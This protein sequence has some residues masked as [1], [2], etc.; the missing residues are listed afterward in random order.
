MTIPEPPCH[1][2]VEF[3][4]AYSYMIHHH[5]IQFQHLHYLHYH[6][7]LHHLHHHGPPGNADPQS[8]WS[9][10]LIYQT[11][12][13]D[14]KCSSTS[15]R[16]PPPPGPGDD[17]DGISKCCWLKSCSTITSTVGW[18]GIPAP[19]A[20]PAPPPP[21]LCQQILGGSCL[22][23]HYHSFRTSPVAD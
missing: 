21:P 16:E 17:S 4:M 5:Q 8:T 23:Q 3:L 1:H 9:I 18:T 19:P 12:T 2:F 7:H 11:T 22:H 13:T 6:H 14:I 15:S 20:P 10:M